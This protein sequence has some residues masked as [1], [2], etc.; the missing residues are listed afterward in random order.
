MPQMLFAIPKIGM[1]KLSKQN[2]GSPK[3][4]ISATKIDQKFPFPG[5]QFR[6][7]FGHNRLDHGEQRISAPNCFPTI[8]CQMD[9]LW[10]S[11]G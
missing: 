1:H 3:R 8:I 4:K 10:I 2:F 9:I 6:Q 11:F 5:V 7:K